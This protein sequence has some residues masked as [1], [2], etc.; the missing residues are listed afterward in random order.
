[1]EFCYKCG[2][3]LEEHC[4]LIIFM[5]GSSDSGDGISQSSI[6]SQLKGYINEYLDFAKKSGYNDHV[7][8]EQSFL[9]VSVGGVEQFNH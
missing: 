6:Y 5:I 7:S 4:D 2:A 1:M 9:N 3:W 8:T